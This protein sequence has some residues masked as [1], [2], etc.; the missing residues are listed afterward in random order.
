MTIPIALKKQSGLIAQGPV[1]TD[2]SQNPGA[3]LKLGTPAVKQKRQASA[4]FLGV[5]AF[6][7]HVVGRCCIPTTILP[8]FSGRHGERESKRDTGTG[9]STRIECASGIAEIAGGNA[10]APREKG[11]S[12]SAA[13]LRIVDPFGSGQL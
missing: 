12:V 1:K 11:R 3:N 8:G 10:Q 6:P 2:C 4:A 9:H 13:A 7:T 5:T